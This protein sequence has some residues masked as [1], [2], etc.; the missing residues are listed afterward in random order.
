MTMKHFLSLR[1]W[2]GPQVEQT[3]HRASELSRLWR[4]GRMPKPLSGK[5]VAFWFHGEGFRNRLAFELGAKEVGATVAYVPGE[6]GVHEP[7]EDIAGYLQNWFSMLVLR[8]RRHEDLLEVA[9]RSNVPVINAR[10]DRSHPCEI[11]GDL[12]HLRER[13]GTIDGLKIVF[14]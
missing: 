4:S 3:L 5:H 1:D 12:L 2:G 10:T 14:V 13:R 6:L 8:T 11:L 9:A 7:I